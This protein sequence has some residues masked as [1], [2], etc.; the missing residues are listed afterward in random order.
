MNIKNT[1]EEDIQDTFPTRIKKIAV[2]LPAPYRGGTLKGLKNIVKMIKLG[3]QLNGEQ[4][5]VV[6]SC[7]EETYD[8]YKDF[9]DLI[10]LGIKINETKWKTISRDSLNFIRNFK[11]VPTGLKESEYILPTDGIN[12]FS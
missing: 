1:F 10:N 5:D 6:F 4:I 12:N 3:S 2:L 8:I 9:A 7:C 11:H